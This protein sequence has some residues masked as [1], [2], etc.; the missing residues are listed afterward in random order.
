[1]RALTFMRFFFVELNFSWIEICGYKIGYPCG[2]WLWGLIGAAHWNKGGVDF[3]A[4]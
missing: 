1:M 3:V 4:K 2:I